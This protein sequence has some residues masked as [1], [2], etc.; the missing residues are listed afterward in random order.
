MSEAARSTPQTPQGHKGGQ[1]A[2]PAGRSE[3]RIIW[4]TGKIKEYPRALRVN[5]KDV[6]GCFTL[7]NDQP[8]AW[9]QEADCEQYGFDF[10]RFM[11]RFAETDRM[12]VCLEEDRVQN[13]RIVW[14]VRCAAGHPYGSIPA[15]VAARQTRSEQQRRLALQTVRQAAQR[16]TGSGQGKPASTASLAVAA[17]TGGATN[18]G[19]AADRVREDHRIIDFISRQARHPQ[20]EDAKPHPTPDAPVK[21]PT[22]TSPSPSIS[23][24]AATPAAGIAGVLEEQAKK[25]PLSSE[26]VQHILNTY[27]PAHQ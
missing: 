25:G 15:T 26:T 2:G 11:A 18:N 1:P 3:G 5:V 4:M 12:L 6:V 27:P 20:A 19:A 17:P 8:G 14:T 13:G 22:S 21:A 23:K 24:S 7:V 16:N 10:T 9:P